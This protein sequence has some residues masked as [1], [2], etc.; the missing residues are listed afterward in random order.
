MADA[1]TTR[2]R[3]WG[4]WIAGGL[5]LFV[6]VPLVALA[7]G[8]FYIQS[9]SG[10]AWL[11]QTLSSLISTPGETEVA[12][13]RIEGRLPHDFQIYDVAVSDAE[14][15]WLT[16]DRVALA[17][18]PTDLL[19]RVF[20]VTA[21]HVDDVRVARLPVGGE[22]EPSGEP[23]R[24]PSL[25]VDIAIDDLAVRD[26]VLAEPVLGEAAAFRVEGKAGAQAAD[27]ITTALTVVRTDGEE[28][29]A[30]LDAAY[31]PD[32]EHLTL[33][34]QVSEPAGGLLARAL[35]LPN[36]P[37]VSISL[38]GAGALADWTGELSVAIDQTLALGADLMLARQEQTTGF[39]LIGSATNK[40]ETDALPWRLAAG[41]TIFEVA[42]A[43][44]ADET[45]LVVD[46]LLLDGAAVH[47]A[48]SG[49][50]AVEAMEVA[51]EVDARLN[52]PAVI[53]V[54]L[55]DAGIAA[56]GL[57]LAARIEGPV[58]QPRIE[59]T[60]SAERVVA[61]GV[62]AAGLET[63]I[64]IDPSAPLDGDAPRAAVVSTGQA[65]GLVIEGG[66]AVNR[67]LD[68]PLEWRLDGAVDLGAQRLEVDDLVLSTGGDSV[69]ASG[70][71]GLETGLI[72][73]GVTIGMESLAALSPLLGFD[74][75]GT[76]TV[77]AWLE[78]TGFG[79]GGQAIV[80]G[81]VQDLTL[82]HPLGNAVLAG[83]STFAAN[84]ARGADGAIAIEALSLDTPT[85][86]VEAEAT[87]SA[88]LQRIEA[89]YTARV[90]DLAILS[91]PL[92]VTVTGA[93]RASGTVAGPVA[94]PRITG[95]VV[96]ND[97]VVNDIA[98]ERFALDYTAAE[99]TGALNGRFDV[100]AET[101]FGAA[102]G[103]AD[104]RLEGEEVALN[105]LRLAGLGA[106][107]EGT[108]TAPLDGRPVA[109]TI[110]LR[111][112]DLTPLLALG[113]LQGGGA[114][115]ATVS[116]AGDTAQ[117]ATIDATLT[118]P[119]LALG[120][121]DA[122]SAA[123][124]DLTVRA[125]DL[126]QTPTLDARA[127]AS[128]ARYGDFALERLRLTAAGTTEQARWTLATSGEVMRPMTLEASGTV[129]LGPERLTL[130][131]AR[132]S[133]R[134][135][136][137]PIRLQRP[138]TFTQAGNSLRLTPLAL[139]F[140]GARV[141][142]EAAIDA[143]TVSAQAR[144]QDLALGS[145]QA[146]APTRDITGRL[147]ANLS[148][149]GP[150]SN[151]RGDVSLRLAGLKAQQV[152]DAPP[153]DLALDGHWANQRLSVTGALS[154]MP[155]EPADLRFALPLRLDAQTLAVSV[156]QDQ[157]MSGRIAWSGN[158]G[159][160]WPLVPQVGNQLSG[161]TDL[162][163]TV[164]GTPANPDAS[165][166]FRLTN[167]T[168]ENLIAGT[169]LRDLTL[170]LTFTRDRIVVSELSATDGGNGRL[171]AQGEAA[172]DPER[173]FPFNVSATLRDFTA[174]RRDEVTASTD[175][176]LTMRGSMER[177]TI[178]GTLTTQGVE[179]RII[180]NLPPRVVDLKVIER[181]RDIKPAATNEQEV[182]EAEGGTD[183]RLDLAVAMPRRVFVRG[184]G[185]DSEW[186]GNLE[187]TGSLSSPSVQGELTLVRGQLTLLTKLFRLRDGNVRFPGGD[188]L[189]PI[190]N[191]TAEHDAGELT[192]IATVQGPATDPEIS[193]SSI[194]PV[195][196][197]EIIARVLF[198]KDS[199]KLSPLE[200]AQL[201]A[202]LAELTGRGGDGGLLGRARGVLGVDVLNVETSEVDG[203]ASPALSAGK[204]VTD[205]VFVG[206]KQGVA[207]GSSAVSVEVELTPNISVES[208]TNATG[209]SDIGINFKWDY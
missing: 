120:G 84:V 77:E 80:T 155:G 142:A 33:D 130:E 203:E 180:D 24:I 152:A 36:L 147:S 133:G 59:A 185:L 16:A 184:R 103:G 31:R 148:L 190:L 109:G 72:D 110:R 145:L 154:G 6:A 97:A 115:S 178:G 83:R 2:G 96:L 140:G 100:S 53:A 200:A 113:G 52:D 160:L 50:L 7:V 122:V 188:D 91:D 71:V 177:M 78:L 138:V 118:R 39:R 204:Y 170:A 144:V 85:A 45:V 134:A 199:S 114:A 146:I 64:T 137:Q 179:I 82:G 48:L 25:P 11:A 105:D 58:T 194:P 126:L 49:R 74:V 4:R 87:V 54:I 62:R 99:V 158:I 173:G 157:P 195:P 43:W 15:V 189:I 156:P 196:Q 81:D 44:R 5:A 102:K 106:E 153:V 186:Q 136:D 88:D 171:S 56:D 10:K 61:P 22:S 67:L 129:A 32:R 40:A 141:S 29:R 107:A 86:R 60:A 116:L 8:Y 139:T 94:N 95:S 209:E 101:Q 13:G 18:Q 9:E 17:W 79:A 187:V 19:K 70:T 41:E 27:R 205:K 169:L 26:V 28:G 191:V 92:G 174:V 37:A 38:N 207:S 69:R 202:A 108:L 143:Q 192:A 21:L 55:P 176:D 1:K 172:I 132:A 3:R 119:R 117:S 135:L 123:R 163:V 168:F 165:G 198:G 131:V 161:P 124:L 181:G 104:Y 12:I 63:T 162:T 93:G 30:A 128:G 47:L 57:T 42:G 46:R 76:A 197:D 201:A 89:A 150:R 75:A 206:V 90:G 20:H 164:A 167:G 127:D 125:D 121:G 65:R 182:I 149:S 34:L 159:S 98:V 166:S 151:P 23:F 112:S 183:I 68:A 73:A 208:E 66:E 193:L 51:A 14:G 35:A 111:A 175:G